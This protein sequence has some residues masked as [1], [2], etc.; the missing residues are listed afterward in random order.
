MADDSTHFID[1]CR[2]HFSRNPGAL[3]LIGDFKKNHASIFPLSCYT[4]DDFIYR[5]VN[6][7]LRRQIIEGTLDLRFFLRKVHKELQSAYAWFESH[8]TVRQ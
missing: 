7:A 6:R 5:I 8:Y 3:K 4:R 2:L 1:Q